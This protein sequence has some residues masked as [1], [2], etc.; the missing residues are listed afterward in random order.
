MF[1]LSILHQ[2]LPSRNVHIKEEEENLRTGEHQHL[3]PLISSDQMHRRNMLTL[4]A[5]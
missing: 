1:S 3:T 5:G 4:F 2:S